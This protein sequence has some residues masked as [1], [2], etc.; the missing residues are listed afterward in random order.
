MNNHGRN[1]LGLLVITAL[2]VS[3]T[4]AWRHWTEP[5]RARAQIQ[6]QTEQRLAVLP[7]H[8][9]DNRPLDAPLALAESQL[10]NSRLQAGYLATLAN[11][12]TAILLISQI[13]G[14]T[15]P[16]TLSIAIAPNGR[17]L[18]SR[19]IGQQ[20]TP[21]LGGRLGEPQ[22][23]WLTQFAGHRSTDH[24]SLRRD[25]G[26]FDQ[27]AGATVTSRAVMTALRE[28]L[29]YFDQHRHALLGNSDHD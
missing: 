27:L 25:G 2:A 18:A 20:E 16:I 3:A 19:V 29:S 17:L 28:A 8:S 7:A 26:D 14:Y 13:Q 22:L 1:I 5:A 24:W 6:L 12:P 15:G 10:P 23:A 21:G 4:L 9:Y 11:R